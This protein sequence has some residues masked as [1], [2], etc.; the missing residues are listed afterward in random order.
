MD[1]CPYYFLAVDYGNGGASRSVPEPIFNIVQ[2][3]REVSPPTS[4]SPVTTPASNIT[5]SCD[6]DIVC[7]CLDASQSMQVKVGCEVEQGFSALAAITMSSCEDLGLSPNY[8][9]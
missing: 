3:H 6:Q 4:V 2:A 7:L 5:S 9:Q 8:N 1:L